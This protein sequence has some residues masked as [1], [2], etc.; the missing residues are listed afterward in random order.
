MANVVETTE[1]KIRRILCEQCALSDDEIT[2]NANLVLDL[3]L[4]SVDKVEVIM[5]CEQIFNIEID[6]SDVDDL[7]TFQQLVAYVE[8]LQRKRRV[9]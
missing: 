6:D 9:G 2:S 3:G 8:K 1:S 7:E 4:D 5:D